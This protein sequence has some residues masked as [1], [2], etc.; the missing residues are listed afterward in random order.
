M[1]LLKN[2][3]I[4][5]EI[6]IQAIGKLPDDCKGKVKCQSKPLYQIECECECYNTILRNLLRSKN[7]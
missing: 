5:Q 1:S 2:K 3:E 4:P 7:L 6:K